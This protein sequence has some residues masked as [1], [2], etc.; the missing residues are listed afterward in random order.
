MAGQIGP[1]GNGLDGPTDTRGGGDAKDPSLR[2][3]GAKLAIALY[4]TISCVGLHDN[5][6]QPATTGVSP[7]WTPV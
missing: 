5:S 4:Q 3:E 7:V 2:R 6:C 1:P